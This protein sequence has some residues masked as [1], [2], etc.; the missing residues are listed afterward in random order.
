MFCFVLEDTEWLI[1]ILNKKYECSR[2]SSLYQF[3]DKWLQE[4]S[5]CQKVYFHPSLA[6]AKDVNIKDNT[7]L[8]ASLW[9][10]I[11]KERK[12][13][14]HEQSLLINPSLTFTPWWL[15]RPG[16]ISTHVH[17]SL[18]MYWASAFHP[19]SC[20]ECVLLAGQIDVV[21]QSHY[22]PLSVWLIIEEEGHY[23]TISN[24]HTYYAQTHF[25]ENIVQFSCSLVWGVI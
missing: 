4:V 5:S 16:L 8:G 3:E 25:N 1:F 23:S 9:T 10:T 7:F 19:C 20:D 14:Q 2:S 11:T 17:C 18:F 24:V 22:D 15:Q 13:I 6:S 21:S 12:H